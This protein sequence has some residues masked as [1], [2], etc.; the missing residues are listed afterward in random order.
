MD[1]RIVSILKYEVRAVTKLYYSGLKH[2]ESEKEVKL[3]V[4]VQNDWF[5]VTHTKEISQVINKTTGE[6][7]TVSRNTLKFEVVS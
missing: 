6:Y 7:I 1:S 3:L 5:E 4:D 2:G